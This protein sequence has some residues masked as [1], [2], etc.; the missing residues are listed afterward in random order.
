M[1]Y[2]L[3][4]FLRGN[5]RPQNKE[6]LFNLRHAS[7]RNVIERSFGVLKKRFPILCYMTNYPV[8]TQIEIVYATVTVHNFIRIYQSIPDK[9]DAYD[10]QDEGEAN[11]D[12]IIE[13]EFNGEQN[14]LRRNDL[15]QWRDNIAESMWTDYQIHLNARNIN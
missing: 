1:R 12:N 6:E 10:D 2:H 9:F 3:K 5:R 15:R 4:E 8:E 13:D 11:D 7:L 14:L